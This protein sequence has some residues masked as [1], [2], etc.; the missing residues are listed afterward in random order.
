MWLR[1]LSFCGAC[2]A[3]THLL[4]DSRQQLGGHIAFIPHGFTL[5]CFVTA[6]ATASHQLPFHSQGPL[7]L[8][9]VDVAQVWPSHSAPALPMWLQLGC[10]CSSWRA[11]WGTAHLLPPVV[12]RGVGWS[13]VV[14]SWVCVC[15][16]IV[17][18]HRVGARH[19]P[20][21]SWVPEWPAVH[22]TSAG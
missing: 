22:S 1:A 19:K 14:V 2:A 13:G 10:P 18:D 4:H 3:S 6:M 9:Q 8:H 15:K 17:C 7:P 20:W 16:H 5:H 21:L 12:Q 11:G